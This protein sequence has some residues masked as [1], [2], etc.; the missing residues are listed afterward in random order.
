M[1]NETVLHLPETRWPFSGFSPVLVYCNA[2]GNK[3]LLYFT[4]ANTP[5]HLLPTSCDGDS[6]F[7]FRGAEGDS[8]EK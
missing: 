6:E 1:Y 5:I 3:S 8:V 7:G 4:L 2:S